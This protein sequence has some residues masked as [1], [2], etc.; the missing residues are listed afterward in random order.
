M[1]FSAGHRQA[2]DR[3][4]ANGEDSFGKVRVI[5]RTGQRDAGRQEFRVEFGR[6]RQERQRFSHVIARVVLG[7]LTVDD[8]LSVEAMYG[9]AESL[10]RDGLDLV[11]VGQRGSAT[12]A[13]GGEVQGIDHTQGKAGMMSIRWRA[14][15]CSFRATD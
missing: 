5:D 11:G 6:G 13:C 7:F 4:P 1:R 12:C 15:A 9:Q 3:L 8:G 2:L 14:A 10:G